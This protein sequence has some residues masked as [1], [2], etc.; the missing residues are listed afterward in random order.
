MPGIQWGERYQMP[1]WCRKV[2]MGWGGPGLGEHSPAQSREGFLGK[3][4]WMEPWWKTSVLGRGTSFCTWQEASGHSLLNENCLCFFPALGL[5]SVVAN[6]GEW[7]RDHMA[8][9]T[10]QGVLSLAWGRWVPWNDFLLFF[11]YH[12]FN[13]IFLQNHSKLFS[14]MNIHIS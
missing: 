9:W 3:C 14:A 10:V 4:M 12:L 2:H 6:K 1:L 5:S 8:I 11:I 13:G 7:S